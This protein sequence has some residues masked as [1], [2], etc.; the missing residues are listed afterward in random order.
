[1]QTSNAWANFL[2]DSDL[3][4]AGTP[5]EKTTLAATETVSQINAL[6]RSAPLRNP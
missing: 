1:M 3:S 4:S 5:S 2:A 6:G